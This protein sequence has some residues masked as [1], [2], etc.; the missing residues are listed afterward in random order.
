MGFSFV[1]HGIVVTRILWA[2]RKFVQI[3]SCLVLF[4]GMA[5]CANRGGAWPVRTIQDLE[6]ASFSELFRS[7]GPPDEL[8][9]TSGD[10]ARSRRSGEPRV[11]W[12]TD[13]FMLVYREQNIIVHTDR[14][15]FVELVERMD[16]DRFK[17]WRASMEAS[18]ASS[19]SDEPPA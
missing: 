13:G 8:F 7:I 16:D 10:I 1:D 11:P 9:E 6:G 18:R 3:F 17:R 4:A 19:V 15:G 5:G 2:M 12:R 14:F